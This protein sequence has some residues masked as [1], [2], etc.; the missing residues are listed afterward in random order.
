[1]YVST[2]VFIYY[3]QHYTDYKL[4]RYEEYTLNT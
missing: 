3:C 2:A 1:M 4:Q